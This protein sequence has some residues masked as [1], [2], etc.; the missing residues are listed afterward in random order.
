MEEIRMIKVQEKELIEF[1]IKQSGHTLQE[2]P[3]NTN[4]HEYEGG[5]MGSISMARFED[6]TYK[7]DLLQVYY[8]DS[9]NTPVII[10][11]TVDTDNNLLDLDFWKEDFSKLITYPG[12]N[13]ISLHK[14]F[15]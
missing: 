11:L 1:M 2:Y 9:D 13:T 5:V 15:S 8:I 3:I 12:I 6:V 4:V 10:T 14:Y 7:E